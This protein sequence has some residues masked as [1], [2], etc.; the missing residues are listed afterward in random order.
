[1]SNTIKPWQ[2]KRIVWNT[3]NFGSNNTTASNQLKFEVGNY[4]A[5]LGES[6]GEIGGEARTMHKSQGEGRPRRKGSITEYFSL[7]AGDSMQ[8]S[9]MDGVATTWSD[10]AGGATVEQQIN[11]IVQQY[12]FEQPN[13]SIPALVSLYKTLQGL[14]NEN[15]WVKQKI[16]EVQQLIVDCAGLFMEATTDTE[17]AVQGEKLNVSFSKQ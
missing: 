13:L 1:L 16:K 15:K 14:Q 11:T 8:T 5:L 9:L 4:N 12:N 3:Y 6:Y 7:T 17:Y 2:A 10:F